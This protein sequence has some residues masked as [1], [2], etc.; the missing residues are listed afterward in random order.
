MNLYIFEGRSAYVSYTRRTLLVYA[1]SEEAAIDLLKK[2]YGGYPPFHASY[3]DP[4]RGHGARVLPLERGIVW[5]D[6]SEMTP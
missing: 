1:E 3:D 2:D 4:W 5:S 6:L